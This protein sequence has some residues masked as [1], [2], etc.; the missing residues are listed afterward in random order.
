MKTEFLKELGLEDGV[1]QKIMA[2]NGKAVNAAKETLATVQKELDELKPQLDE[3]NKTIESFGDYEDTKAAVGEWK[4]KYEQLQ[5]AQAEKQA[6]EELEKKINAALDGAKHPDLLM[7]A[8]DLNALKESKN[9]DVDIKAQADSIKE[10]YKDAWGSA[11]PFKNPVGGS[12]GSGGA[13][14][15]TKNPWQKETFNLTEQGKLLKENPELAKQM[16]A[17]K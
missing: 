1:I 15:V 13:G 3:A 8:F 12:G 2:E 9:L 4:E 17:E 6:Q 16:M 5:T 11:E 14:G 7:K 10:K